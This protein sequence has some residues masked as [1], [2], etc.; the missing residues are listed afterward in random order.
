MTAAMLELDSAT[1]RY[2]GAD[3]AALDDVSLSVSAGELVAVTG[4][5]GSGKTSLLRGLLGLVPLA[6]GAAHIEGRPTGA[7][8]RSELAQA[9]GVVTQR[10]ETVFPLRV[11]EAVLLGRYARLGPLSPVS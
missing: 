1:V 8:P 9:V 4:P 6:R 2:A 7:W 11:D 5:N 10:E 3:R